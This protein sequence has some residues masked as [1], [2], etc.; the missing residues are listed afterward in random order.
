M[1]PVVPLR[2]FSTEAVLF[3]ALDDR[4]LLL[5][6]MSRYP[7]G[8]SLVSQ[9]LDIFEE[10]VQASYFVERPSVWGCPMF[11]RDWTYAR[12]GRE[13]S[14]STRCDADWLGF[15]A[16][17]PQGYPASLR[18]VQVSCRELLACDGPVSV[19]GLPPGEHSR[20]FLPVC[21]QLVGRRRLF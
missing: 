11:P 4:T 19:V 8:T 12:R 13:A 7:P 3:S 14:G 16:P 2:P 6:V 10:D 17:P 18:D 15:Q 21:H 1:W 9:D 20:W 5:V